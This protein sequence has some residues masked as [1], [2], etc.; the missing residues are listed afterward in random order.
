MNRFEAESILRAACGGASPG[1]DDLLKF[2]RRGFAF[3]A[4]E[5]KVTNHADED[6]LGAT[7]LPGQPFDFEDDAVESE[8]RLILRTSTNIGSKSGPWSPDYEDGPTQRVSLSGNLTVWDISNFP[9]GGTMNFHFTM[10]E[11]ELAFSGTYFEGAAI[12]FST[13]D[14]TVVS[15]L[16]LGLGK[17]IVSGM[18]YS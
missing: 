1:V 13:E 12:S 18:V 9:D 10:N 3:G 16:D 15:V 17:L 5:F 14:F 2:T 8:P 7:L 6:I 11:H 4:S